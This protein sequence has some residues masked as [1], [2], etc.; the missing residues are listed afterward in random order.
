[1]KKTKEFIVRQATADDTD[2]LMHMVNE[3]AGA[4][5]PQEDLA[6]N[7]WRISY[8]CNYKRIFT[9]ENRYITFLAENPQALGF[10]TGYPYGSDPFKFPKNPPHERFY[11]AQVYVRPGSRNQGIAGLLTQAIEK[12][13]Q[14]LNYHEMMADTKKWN[15][16]AIRT[17]EKIG[18]EMDPIEPGSQLIFRKELL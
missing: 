16:P 15:K 2:T 13:A 8:R 17:L 9:T 18:Y 7:M 6:T 3:L 11:I 4:Q 10:I 14:S 5:R 12:Y 1:M